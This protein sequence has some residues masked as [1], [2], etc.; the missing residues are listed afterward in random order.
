MGKRATGHR[1]KA[2]CS[3]NVAPRRLEHRDDRNPAGKRLTDPGSVEALHLAGLIE[4]QQ[5]RNAEALRLIG[6][7]L[8][9]R[10]D[11]APALANYGMVLGALKRHEEALATFDRVLAKGAGDAVLH[12]NRGN[13]L[14]YLGR[15]NEALASYERALSLDPGLM[16]A[17]WNSGNAFAALNRYEDA[18]AIYDIALLLAPQCSDVCVKRANAA[19]QL[20]RLDE[21]LRAAE[22]ALA[23]APD[24][25]DALNI[26]GRILA[27]LH[28]YEAALA[29]YDA[30]LKLAPN[31]AEAH[32]NRGAALF[33]LGRFDLAFASYKEALHIDPDF[34]SAYLNQGNAYA[35]L[36]RLPE[37]LANYAA[38]LAREPQHADANFNE[39]LARLCLGDF[40][41]GWAKYENRWRQAKFAAGRP[42][43]PRPIWR[44]E[45]AITGKTILLCAEQGMGDAIQFVRYAPLVA[46]LGANVLLGVYRPLAG[47][48][49]SVPGVSAVIADGATL[50]DFDLYC[51]LLSLP[52]VFGTE[53]ATIP[54]QVPYI[55]PDPS[56]IEQWRARVPNNGRLRVGICW[57]G[58]TA[59]VADRR[60]SIPLDQ[61]TTLLSVP[62]I[63]FVSLQKDVG[64]QQAVVLRNHDVTQL[65]D[66]FRDFADT[67]AVIALLDLVITVDTSVA[68]LAGAMGKAVGMLV[69]FSPDWRWMLDRTDTPWYPTMRLFRQSA[70][71]DW[72]GPLARLRAELTGVAQP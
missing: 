19:M 62:G 48:M 13:A 41:N 55:R 71:G 2:A 68:H 54:S 67:A 50:P 70:L 21:A 32:S 29:S 26:H 8:Q 23:N 45:T 6:K 17:Y 14:K 53:L 42:N 52:F 47:L 40:R 39:S 59:H 60:R 66:D 49:A 35:A 61:F 20:G 3:A 43:F 63:D 25:V 31:D 24:S 18:I 22:A 10:P 65:G 36:N 33:E 15:D 46:A 44:G 5:G 72:H 57:A 38:V 27:R 9:T 51:M 12:Y 1:A 58:S 7:A 56:R 11:S 69:A 4:Y 37:A 64:V 28:R 30:A 34:V 16:E